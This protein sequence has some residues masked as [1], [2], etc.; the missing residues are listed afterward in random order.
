M[1][2]EMLPEFENRM[3]EIAVASDHALAGSSA[4]E[5]LMRFS[6][7][8]RLS[9]L[10]ERL[11][12]EEIVELADEHFVLQ[13]TL[14]EYLG[15]GESTVAGWFKNESIPNAP[16]RAIVAQYV[17]ERL[18]EELADLT[19]TERDPFP[20][21]DGD[22]FSLVSVRRD[23]LGRRSGEII[24][25]GIMGEERANKLCS[26][27][28]IA[29]SLRRSLEELDNYIELT[30]YKDRVRAVRKESLE[31]L[32]LSFNPDRLRERRNHEAESLI[33]WDVKS[34]KFVEE[35]NLSDLIG[36]DGTEA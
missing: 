33:E 11:R 10:V 26:A 23:D 28:A 7:R 1:G 2:E 16:A 29:R 15:V 35:F 36:E 34:K 3:R 12:P 30:D 24:A 13:K 9:E 32:L 31:T 20:I 8:T 6:S 18:A 27:P 21:K 17:A 5:L 14:S 4:R 25:R 22:S 19:R